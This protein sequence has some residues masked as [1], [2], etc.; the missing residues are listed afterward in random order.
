MKKIVSLLILCLVLLLSHVSHAIG[1]NG[2]SFEI[3]YRNGYLLNKLFNDT[4]ANISA[5]FFDV[6]VY[7]LVVLVHEKNGLITDRNWTKPKPANPKRFYRKERYVYVKSHSV[8]EIH[9][10]MDEGKRFCFEADGYYYLVS[11]A[12]VG[13][14]INEGVLRSNFLKLL[15]KN[16]NVTFSESIT[17]ENIPV[18]QRDLIEGIIEKMLIQES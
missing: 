9:T 6:S 3:E 5:R 18:M 14:K 11:I 12:K 1:H 8:R 16:G 4:P 2:V 7:P 10:A 15:V 13:K 17:R